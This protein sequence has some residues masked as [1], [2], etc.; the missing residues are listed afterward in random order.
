MRSQVHATGTPSVTARG[1]DPQKGP[2]EAEKAPEKELASPL[3]Y[4]LRHGNPRIHLGDVPGLEVQAA[5]NL[6]K[7]R[8]E[9]KKNRPSRRC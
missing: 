4:S 9:W 6:A 7:D 2:Q 5:I 8:V 3:H 1:V